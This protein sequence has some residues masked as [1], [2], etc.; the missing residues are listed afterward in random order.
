LTQFKADI[1]SK[2]MGTGILETALHGFS[3]QTIRESGGYTE[4]HG[5]TYNGQME[6]IVKG[7]NFLEEVLNKEVT[8]FI[9]PYG[10]YDLNT[11]RCLEELKFKC[12][13][14]GI[15]GDVLEYSS[16]KFLPAS[17][18][19]PQLR[20]AIET[21]KNLA[22]AQS[23]IIVLFHEYDFIEINK[24][25]GKLTYQEFVELLNWLTS[26]ENV[27]IVS[28]SQAV[29]RIEDLSTRRFIYNKSLFRLRLLIPP[30]LSKLYP[31]HVGIYLTSETARE[32]KAK[33]WIVV[34]IYYLT[35]LILT[36][37]MAFWAGLFIFPKSRTVTLMS[38]CGGLALLL[39]FS[40]YALH[41]LSVNYRG[42]TVI[43]VLLGGC[44]GVWS[45]FLRLKK[46]DRV[47]HLQ[48]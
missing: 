19:L 13:S 28:I 26:L 4:F 18:D 43:A 38:K 11:I 29:K 32:I 25:R 47:K 37:A 9:P 36:A 8:T 45:S 22:E 7:K 5:L 12:I 27:H 33:L 30:L 10:S 48:E 16:L 3:H 23:V 40:I 17:C 46:Q 39:L 6:K 21:A 35:I 24:K 14:A 31:K 42:T 2:A 34:S 20:D 44:I 41:N 15:S 1:L